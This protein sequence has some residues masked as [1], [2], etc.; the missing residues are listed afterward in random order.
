MEPLATM[1]ASES[2]V[3]RANAYHAL[4]KALIPP[5]VWPSDLVGAMR[6]AFAPFG[7]PLAGIGLR[8][9]EQAT[10]GLENPEELA[11]AHAQLFIGPFE[12]SAAPWASFYL[13]PDQRLMGA[14]S[15]YAAK[16]YAAVGLGPQV[17]PC[18][19]PDHVTHELEFMYFLAF[20][21][22]T[23]GDPIWHARQASFWTG[24][25]GLW[26]PDLARSMARAGTHPFY[27]ALAEA[28]IEFCLLEDALLNS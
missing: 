13:D 19:A 9:V 25:L 26:L 15:E 21:G 23:T 10:A 12:I 16:S 28:L 17:G 27:Q 22:S 6:D 8:V 24:H 5:S 18:D 3:R 14:A 7:G 11:A 2:G 4:A 1:A 20:Q